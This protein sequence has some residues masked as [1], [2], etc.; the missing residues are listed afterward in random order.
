LEQGST[1]Q[2]YANSTTT[3][4]APVPGTN[5]TWAIA[6]SQLTPS[7]RGVTVIQFNPGR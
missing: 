3:N 7:S 1:L 6:F 2:L 4:V 5:A